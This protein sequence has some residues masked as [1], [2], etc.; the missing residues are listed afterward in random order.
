MVFYY[1]RTDSTASAGRRLL[2]QMDGDNV[3][4][5]SATY[6]LNQSYVRQAAAERWCMD[7]GGHLVGYTSLEEQVRL[8]W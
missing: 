7:R 8:Q 5:T 6:I 2:L 1:N 4:L 3:T